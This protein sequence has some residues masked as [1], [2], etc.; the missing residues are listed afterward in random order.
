L[1]DPEEINKNKEFEYPLP[2]K[3]A[4]Y[5]P[6]VLVFRNNEA[7]GYTFMEEVVEIDIIS[8]AAIRKPKIKYSRSKDQ[9]LLEEKDEKKMKKK[10][11]LMLDIALENNHTTLVLSA[12]ECGA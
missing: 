8:I 11:E 1:E 6:K 12:F 5:S 10:I 4:I 2:T 9:Y 3:S 7:K